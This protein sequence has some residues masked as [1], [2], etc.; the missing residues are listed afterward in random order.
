M[1]RK[2]IN[3]NIILWTVFALVFFGGAYLVLGQLGGGLGSV[4]QKPAELIDSGWRIVMGR[5][6]KPDPTVP[7]N[8]HDV[9]VIS[10]AVAIDS[11]GELVSCLTDVQAEI[12][13]VH[14][15]LK[16][17][18]PGISHEQIVTKALTWV[19]NDH[20]YGMIWV[21]RS[22]TTIEKGREA[23]IARLKPLVT[24]ALKK[25]P[26]PGCANKF[27]RPG[28]HAFGTLGGEG[29]AAKVIRTYP[30]DP[31][32][33]GKACKIDFRCAPPPKSQ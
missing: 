9:R 8:E 19:P 28:F 13:Q 24:A 4:V 22:I 23:T 26:A 20:D 1:D 14:L 21:D 18:L 27:V 3:V 32:W 6:A 12:I 16:K 31:R 15:R 25:E 33:E 2:P 30:K 17:S 29:G 7:P 10:A 11:T 5:E